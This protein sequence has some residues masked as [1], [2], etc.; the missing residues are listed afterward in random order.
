MIDIGRIDHVCL[1]VADLDEASARWAV[2]F[3]LHETE[4]RDGRAYLACAYEPYCLELVADGRPGHDHTGFELRRD[5]TLADAAAH[6][7]EEVGGR[8]VDVARC[9]HLLEVEMPGA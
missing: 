3:G 8:D 5:T 9:R 1:R 4:R 7:E 6:R 2:Q